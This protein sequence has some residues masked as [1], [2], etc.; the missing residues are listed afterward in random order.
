MRNPVWPS[1]CV[2]PAGTSNELD[3]KHE[4][5]ENTQK[6][7]APFICSTFG[8][9][10]ILCTIHSFLSTFVPDFVQTKRLSSLSFKPPP[11]LPARVPDL[12]RNTRA[13]PILSISLETTGLAGASDLCERYRCLCFCSFVHLCGARTFVGAV[14]W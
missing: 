4:R 11:N 6:P 9:C 13:Y 8:K 3:V 5:E 12:L 14:V 7:H 1:S 2:T 10:P